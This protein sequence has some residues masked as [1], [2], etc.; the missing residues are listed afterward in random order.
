MRP[1]DNWARKVE[2]LAD[3]PKIFRDAAAAEFDGKQPYALF[4]PA[5]R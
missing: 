1:M 4:A 3:V 5:E 2:N